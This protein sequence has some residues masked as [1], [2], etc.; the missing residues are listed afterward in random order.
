[1]MTYIDHGDEVKDTLDEWGEPQMRKHMEDF[2]KGYRSLLGLLRTSEEG[3]RIV[4]GQ[5]SDNTRTVTI[6]NKD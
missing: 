3:Q 2:A 6:W 5:C 1:M 4:E